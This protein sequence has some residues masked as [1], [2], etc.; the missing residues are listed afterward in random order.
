M[1]SSASTDALIA[2]EDDPGAA[3]LLAEPAPG[4]GIPVWPLLRWPAVREL[5][6]IDLGSDNVPRPVGRAAVLAR[7]LDFAIPGA[8]S[9]RRIRGRRS[10]LVLAPGSRISHTPRGTRDQLLQELL[11]PLAPDVLVLRD[12]PLPFWTRREDRPAD[13]YT[14]SFDDAVF[15]S[16]LRARYRPPSDEHLAVVRRTASAILDALPHPIDDRRRGVALRALETRYRRAG[17]ALQSFGRVLDR[18]QPSLLLVQGAAYGDRAHL[19]AEAHRRGI[20]VAE[21]QHGW[22]GPSH[23]AYNFGASASAEP[24]RATLPDHLLTF[25]ELWGEGVRIPFP[26]TPIGRPAMTARRAAAPPLEMRPRRVLVVGGVH[27][28]ERTDSSTVAIR[29]ALPAD[30]EV[31]FR[32]H[33]SERPVLAQRFPA[34]TAHPG[35]AI[36]DEPDVLDSLTQARGVVGLAS[37]V[38]YEALA[39]GCVVIVRDSPTFTDLYIAGEV[40]PRVVSDGPELEGALAEVVAGAA[41]P[42]PDA[43]LDRVWAPDPVERFQRFVSS[44]TGRG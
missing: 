24:Q 43:V 17:S 8:R 21:P 31:L 25:G 26:S 9:S 41:Q 33:P 14:A 3:H 22:I 35:I 20:L 4:I 15:R 12:R 23:P 18:I 2:L 37:T 38:L 28:P 16:E 40:F 42:V 13:R 29:A 44:H 11:D 7:A 19:V 10:T 5:R 36:D 30:W 6:S 1:K 27:E 32:P 39:V 34:I